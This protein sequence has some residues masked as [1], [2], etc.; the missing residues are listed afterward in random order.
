MANYI[1]KDLSTYDL[2]S[3][4]QTFIELHGEAEILPTGETM[5][6]SGALIYMYGDSDLTR[7]IYDGALYLP[8]KKEDTFLSF[9]PEQIKQSRFA[10]THY[11]ALF[12]SECFLLMNQNGLYARCHETDVLY[13]IVAYGTL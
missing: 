8:S 9:E 3:A 13:P 4:T 2:I 5:R 7:R 10:Y 1:G 12:P 6:T 11:V